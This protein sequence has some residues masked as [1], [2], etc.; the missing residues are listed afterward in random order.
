[1]QI[2]GKQASK[3]RNVDKDSL[4]LHKEENGFLIVY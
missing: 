2:K 3:N 1:M 4:V